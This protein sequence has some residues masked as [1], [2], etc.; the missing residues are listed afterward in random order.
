VII[1]RKNASPTTKSCRE[2]I[3]AHKDWQVDDASPRRGLGQPPL[4]GQ[5]RG[6]GSLQGEGGHRE[7]HQGC[8]ARRRQSRAGQTELD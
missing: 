3:S 2:A 8:Q 1:F 7:A 5:P 4:A 6:G